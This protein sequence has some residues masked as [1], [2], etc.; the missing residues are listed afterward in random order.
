ML[1]TDERGAA[2][3]AHFP[4]EERIAL[5]AAT[6]R[7][8]DPSGMARAGLAIVRGTLQ[9]R[10]AFARIKPAVV[11]G[12]GGYPSVPALLAAITAGRRTLIHEQNAVMGRANRLLAPRVSAVACAFPTLMKAD[13]KV[14]R[15]RPGGRQSGAAG[16]PRPGRRRLYAARRNYPPA[17]HRRQPRRAAAVRTGSPAPSRNCPKR[18]ARG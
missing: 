7:P 2:F 14:A 8:G 4:A 15:P 13:P 9:A 17:D 18:C 10:A 11:V 16:D 12:F 5:T 3:A 6:Y 1:A